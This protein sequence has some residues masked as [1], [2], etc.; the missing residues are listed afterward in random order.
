MTNTKSLKFHHGLGDCANA[1]ALFKLYNEMGIQPVISCKP[2]KEI[3]FKGMGCK[4]SPSFEQT[5]LWPH[6]SY[7]EIVGWDNPW[8]DNKTFFNINR[9]PL[10]S[11]PFELPELWK[12]LISIKMT[13]GDLESKDQIADIFG[14]MNK[15]PAPYTLLHSRGTTGSA[16]K[17]F[18]PRLEADFYDY[19]YK[20]IP[21]TLILLDWDNRVLMPEGKRIVHANKEFGNISV[22]QLYIMMRLADAFIGVDSGPLHFARFVPELPCIGCWFGFNPSAFALPSRNIANLCAREHSGV[23]SYGERS[24]YTRA[25]PFR[26]HVFNMVDVPKVDGPTIGAL[27]LEA[28]AGRNARFGEASCIQ[29]ILPRL[30]HNRGA[31]GVPVDRCDSAQKVLKFISHISSPT[32]VETGC[33]RSNDDWG[34]GYFGYWMGMYLRLHGAGSLDSVDITPG[35]VEIAKKIT[36]DFPVKT[37]LSDS[38]KWLSEYKGEPINLLYLDSMDTDVPHHAEHCLKE[39]EAGIKKL[40]SNCAILIDDT[41]MVDGALKGKG[42]LAVPWLVTQGFKVIHQGY[43]SLLV[44]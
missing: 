34:A 14:W 28:L 25:L 44:R 31:L 37:H 40:S 4:I 16:H 3:V 26:R 18:T 23:N 27:L 29:N 19:F 12:E 22:G 20:N 24:R 32:I 9:Q 41:A 7:K 2:D 39:A 15:Y 33:V 13:L 6:P 43:Q 17:S 5:H 35:N 42:R 21:G 8:V 38:V 11:L 1:A 30:N 36:K 10:P